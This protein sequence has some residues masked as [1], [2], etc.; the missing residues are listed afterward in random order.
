MKED[1]ID[2]TI[3]AALADPDDDRKVMK[4]VDFGQKAYERVVSRLYRCPDVTH[5]QEGDDRMCDLV[6]RIATLDRSIV[7]ENIMHSD[8]LARSRV[9]S[10]AMV[11]GFPE[12]TDLIIDRLRDRSINVLDK[13]VWAIDRH[14]RLRTEKA[15]ELLKALLKKKIANRLCVPIARVEELVEEI[16]SNQAEQS[17]RGNALPRAPQL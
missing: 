7:T 10:A 11:S 16:E 12:F 5:P 6:V 3:V 4:V 13:A 15:A 1:A 9:V 14:Q 8:S 2:S 17:A